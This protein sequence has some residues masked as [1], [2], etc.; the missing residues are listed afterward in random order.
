[1]RLLH[2][3]LG[4][5]MLT[6]VMCRRQESGLCTGKGDRAELPRT[7]H[8]VQSRR[9]LPRFAFA[10]SSR[11]QARQEEPQVTTSRYW[12]WCER[13]EHDPGGTRWRWY[14]WSRG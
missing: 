14:F 13:R 3:A 5:E 9:L 12:R 10:E 2:Y 11:R 8:H 7:S 6:L 4:L 1:M